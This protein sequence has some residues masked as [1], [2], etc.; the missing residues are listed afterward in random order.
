MSDVTVYGIPASTYVRTARMTLEEKGVAYDLQPFPPHS[1]EIDAL[2]PF[3]KVPAF[4]HGD[5]TLFETIAI[6]CYVDDA[7]DGPALQPK[8]GNARARMLQWVSAYIDNTYPAMFP[9]VYQRLVVPTQGG[10]SDEDVIAEAV[11]KVRR[12]LEVFDGALA[13]APWLAGDDFSLADMFPAPMV[14]Y[15]R[16]MPEGESLLAGIG[17][18]GRWYEV[19]AGRQSFGATVPSPD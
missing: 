3:G 14:F 5:L 17:N 12:Q 18:L 2:H 9:L 16:I 6:G 13:D 19:V 4:R 1:P 8:N 7:F 11:P 15:L 10:T